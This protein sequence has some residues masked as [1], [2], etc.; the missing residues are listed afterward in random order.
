MF[1]VFCAGFCNL[2]ILKS[3]NE[4]RVTNNFQRKILLMNNN[5]N[6]QKDRKAN[7]KTRNFKSGN[8]FAGISQNCYVNMKLTGGSEKVLSLK[9]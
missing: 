9:F 2:K 7:S 3:K 4:R 8:F 6:I 5:F 1:F